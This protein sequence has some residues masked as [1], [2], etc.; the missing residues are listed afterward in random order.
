MAS[1]I[2]GRPQT[3]SVRSAAEPIREAYTGS[4]REAY[5]GSIGWYNEVYKGGH[6]QGYKESI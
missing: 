4:I 5:T 3:M 6:I 2:V 1:I